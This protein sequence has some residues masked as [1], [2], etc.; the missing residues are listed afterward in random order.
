MK[1]INNTQPIK[2]F[3]YGTL[4][5]HHKFNILLQDSK[6]LGKD[7]VVGSLYEYPYN[8]PILFTDGK[9]LIPGEVWEVTGKE[10]RYIKEMEEG[11]QYEEVTT[12]TLNNGVVKVFVGSKRWNFIKTKENKIREW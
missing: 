10:Y 11:A 6:L 7:E 9:D 5:T 8:F 12:V 4:K 2:L 1:P 3:V